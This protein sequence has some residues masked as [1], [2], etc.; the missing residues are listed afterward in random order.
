MPRKT[1]QQ[2]IEEGQRAK[3]VVTARPP[4]MTGGFAFAPFL[5]FLAAAATPLLG[6]AGKWIGKKVF[7]EG[8]RPAGAVPGGAGLQR[9]GEKPTIV[10]PLPKMPPVKWMGMGVRKHRAGDY[11]MPTMT[12][13]C[14][15]KSST[16]GGLPGAGWME[17][18]MQA[19]EKITKTAKGKGCKGGKA[20]VKK[21][22]AAA[23]A[24][25]AALRAMRKKK[26]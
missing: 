17:D 8:L 22:S 10:H 3:K 7:G 26:T 20:S 2:L 9:A 16:T 4:V 13:L 24:K 12:P 6:S 5:P 19:I 18:T 11:P 14:H 1:E 25:M 15:A 23:K 21:G